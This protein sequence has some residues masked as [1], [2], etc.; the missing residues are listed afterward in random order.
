MFDLDGVP[1]LV[2]APKDADTPGAWPLLGP[3]A[4]AQGGGGG[5]EAAWLY[6]ALNAGAGQ[7]DH[8]RARHGGGKEAITKKIP[9]YAL[10]AEA[11]NAIR[12]RGQ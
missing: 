10:C 3:F 4:D 5:T 8:C 2:T 9:W 7:A 6:V 11:R 12:G 1:G